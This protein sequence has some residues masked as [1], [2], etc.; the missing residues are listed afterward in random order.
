MSEPIQPKTAT[1]PYLKTGNE[2]EHCK[3]C[4]QL[5][6]LQPKNAEQAM[7]HYVNEKGEV[8]GLYNSKEETLTVKGVKLVR[9]DLFKT[10]VAAPIAPLPP[11]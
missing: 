3:A 1:V 6:P 7:N 2:P 5:L 8:D 4:G 10:K 9:K 11:K